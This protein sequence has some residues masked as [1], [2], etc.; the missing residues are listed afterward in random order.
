[1]ESKVTL[2]VFLSCFLVFGFLALPVEAGASDLFKQMFNVETPTGYSTSEIG[3]D[4]CG[5]GIGKSIPRK[6]YD[7]N[8]CGWRNYQSG[9]NNYVKDCCCCYMNSHIHDLG[10][11]FSPS[12]IKIEYK[13]GLYEDC[14]SDMYVFYSTDGSNWSRFHSQ[15]VTQETWR[16]KT[17][18][19]TNL[20][21]PSEF[22]Y[23]K[24][25][26]PSCNVDYSSV[27]VLESTEG[28]WC[29]DT[30]GG[31]N[32][33]EKGTL[34]SSR[35]EEEFTDSCYNSTRLLEHYCLSPTSGAYA[36][37]RPYNCP[38]GYTCQDGACVSVNTGAS[39]TS[40]SYS[41]YMQKLTLYI[42]NTGAVN[43]STINAMFSLEDSDGD[44][45][46]GSPGT[47]HDKFE[48]EVG[49]EDT[50][51][52]E[53]GM[54]SGEVN[55]LGIEIN[56]NTCTDLEEGER[57]Y[58][59]LEFSEGAQVSG[60]FAVPTNGTQECS[61][62]GYK[63]TSRVRGC[64]HYERLRLSCDSDN[65]VCCEEIPYCGDGVCFEYDETASNCPE[66]C[67]PNYTYLIKRDIGEL[68]YRRSEYDE[69]CKLTRF[70]GKCR[71]EWGTYSYQSGEELIAYIEA[72]V[73]EHL[74]NDEAVRAVRRIR[75][76]EF[77]YIDLEKGTYRGNKV[78][79]LHAS[80]EEYHSHQTQQQVQTGVRSITGEASTSTTSEQIGSPHTR[81]I[82]LLAA[83]YSNGKLII[84]GGT[85]LSDD[86]LIGPIADA[87][88]GRYP[89][90]LEFEDSDTDCDG[91]YYSGKCYN[92]E[93]REM[94]DEVPSYCNYNDQFV[95]Q[96]GPKERCNNNY[97]CKSNVC[98]DGKCVEGSMLRRVIEWIRNYVD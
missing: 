44:Q 93:H 63:C 40:Q 71:T 60:S 77:S 29:N 17:T 86:E 35:T 84:V 96:N 10:K 36:S 39:L 49:C 50:Q 9:T 16:P 55:K 25:N 26:I 5:N 34:R 24:I 43:L 53:V 15:E 70:N 28:E 73:E 3:Y 85:H 23:V 52:R 1:M 7:I 13:P 47:F 69:E 56:R 97:E 83:W 98:L 75:D 20:N 33:Y 22:R 90:D 42:Q 81:H 67:S 91:C 72:P 64:G 76:T 74:S 4:E 79:I 66:D 68:Q 95:A 27:E 38:N 31:S 18:Y 41:D 87:Y 8:H 89:S 21:V 57:Y 94:I 11:T 45:V 6:E 48:C 12:E 78:F 88:L 32:I 62:Q 58:F 37:S 82:M 2:I 14:S 59:K 61:R 46:C 30:D 19:S 54:L 80:E 92:Y 51:G 65:L